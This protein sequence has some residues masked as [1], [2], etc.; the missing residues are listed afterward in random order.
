MT[1]GE[2][3]ILVNVNTQEIDQLKAKLMG[4]DGQTKKTQSGFAK[5]AASFVTAQTAINL[6]NRGLQMSKQYIMNS[7]NNA[8]DLNEETNKFGVVF[9]NT[10][11]G[12]IENAKKMRDELVKSYGMSR[13][14]ATKALSA[15]GDFLVPMGLAREEAAKLSGNFTKLAV[16]IGSFNNAPTADVLE[17]IKSAIAGMSRPLR[18]YGIDVSETTLKNMA[19]AKGIEV[20]GGKLDQQTRIQLIYE[21]VLQDSADARGDFGRTSQDLANR[22]KILD[23]VQKDISSSLGQTLLPIVNKIAGEFLDSAN[24]IKEWLAQ[25]TNLQ[26]VFKTVKT[27]VLVVYALGKAIQ[28]NFKIMKDLFITPWIIAGKV[29]WEFLKPIANVITKVKEAAENIKKFLQPALETIGGLFKSAKEKATDFAKSIGIK[30]ETDL[31]EGVTNGLTVLQNELKKTGESYIKFGQ[32][33]AKGIKEIKDMQL[34]L[35]TGE[36]GIVG[37]AGTGAEDEGGAKTTGGG[38]EKTITYSIN[39]DT[40]GFDS[41]MDEMVSKLGQIQN[42]V[43]DGV[44]NI[45]NNITEMMSN[46]AD[47]TTEL[48]DKGFT[49]GA[50]KAVSAMETIN[51]AAQAV[52]ETML[53]V[54][55]MIQ[56]AFNEYYEQQLE[57]LDEQHNAEI[58]AIDEKLAAEIELIEND[59]MTKEEAREAELESLQDQLSRETDATKRKDLQEKISTITKEKEIA[60]AQKKAL[61]KKEKQE[62]KYAKEKYKIEVQQFET[63][64]ALEII[65]ATINYLMG[66]VNIWANVWS[67]GP[68]AGAIMGGVL[69][70][71]LT[72][73]FVASVAM[74]ASQQPPPPPSFARGGISSGGIATVGEEGAE[75]VNLPAG[76][77]IFDA[78]TSE[79]MLKP[80]IYLNAHI[81]MDTEEIPIKKVL[82]DIR[83]K[84]S[85]IS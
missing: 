53:A 23:S 64:K 12:I 70:G 27:V 2:L 59:G 82:L 44:T 36:S 25:E 32:D 46:M 9:R 67:L 24:S 3:E 85:I 29:V 81:Y 43:I 84:E 14:E 42:T 75:R 49:E 33:A 63:A 50:S 41:E 7:I 38:K 30:F 28:L 62:K 65:M 77:Q 1:A 80:N 73:F 31:P 5:M 16:D 11:G 45:A 21:K 54:I 19:M 35:G 18:Q 76:S 4:L 51:V 68:I 71:I 60:E 40:S 78:D 6:F 8:K 47:E 74:I 10:T 39:I 72:G 15:F 26:K 22:L 55:E 69:T 17:G 61:E 83:E 58:E 52:G 20:V 57:A 79:G 37:G 48:L 56:E 66:L 13:L 34:D